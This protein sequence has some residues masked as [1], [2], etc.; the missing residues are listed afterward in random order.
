MLRHHIGECAGIG[1]D[2]S[3]EAPLLFNHIPQYRL[4]RH[5]NVVPGVVSGHEGVAAPLLDPHAKG[6][7]IVLME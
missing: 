4:D 6:H 1:A 2:N 5:G 7:S 3:V